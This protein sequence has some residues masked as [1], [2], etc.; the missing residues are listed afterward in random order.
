[1]PCHI[2][3]TCS[4]RK[5]EVKQHCV[6]TELTWEAVEEL[7]GL[8]IGTAERREDSVKAGPPSS[9]SNVLSISGGV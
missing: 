4:N 7:L 3:E 5:T 9:V 1:M 6:G 2:R 8:D